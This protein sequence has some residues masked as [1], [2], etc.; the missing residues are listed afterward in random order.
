MRRLKEQ[1]EIELDEPLW[2]GQGRSC[3]RE[4]KSSAKAPTR[5]W[6]RSTPISDR[7]T[8]K[9]EQL[10]KIIEKCRE[11]KRKKKEKE[12]R[13]QLELNKKEE[14]SRRWETRRL[15]RQEAR[16]QQTPLTSKVTTERTTLTSKEVQTT[17]TGK[18]ASKKTAPKSI[19]LITHS[20]LTTT[21]DRDQSGSQESVSQED[22]RIPSTLDLDLHL[23]EGEYI[24]TSPQQIGEIVGAPKDLQR[25]L[26]LPEIQQSTLDKYLP[27][28]GE[29]SYS[30]GKSQDIS[31]PEIT[32]GSIPC[33]QPPSTVKHKLDMRDLRRDSTDSVLVITP[34]QSPVQ[35]PNKEDSSSSFGPDNIDL[36][37]TT[38]DKVREAIDKEFHLCMVIGPDIASQRKELE[39]KYEKL[40][41]ELHK[42]LES[43]FQEQKRQAKEKYQNQLVV[44]KLQYTDEIA[45]EIAKIDKECEEG[46]EEFHQTID[47]KKQ[48]EFKKI[49]EDREIQQRKALE[50]SEQELADYQNNLKGRYRV[51]TAKL[52]KHYQEK[53]SKL[54]EEEAEKFHQV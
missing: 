41:E 44:V 22:D 32:G 29:A 43:E 2:A 14:E 42:K 31:P 10:N 6:A 45:E 20:E 3:D 35:L 4:R 53:Y 17:T 28:T 27:S 33:A 15:A 47:L 8:I 38:V 18:G 26:P 49:E 23:S 9:T 34:T 25:L 16:E 11:E 39:E 40:H 37:E 48:Q 19:Q 50:D 54:E 21:Y 5:S 30:Q 51:K 46:V 1:T 13:K 12:E 36:D 24:P 7:E 52:K